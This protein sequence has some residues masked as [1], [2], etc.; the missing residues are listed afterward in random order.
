MARSIT[1]ERNQIIRAWLGELLLEMGRPREALLYYE[2]LG[3]GWPISQDP[4]IYFHLGRIRDQ[5]GDREG[6]LQS[7]ELATLAWRDADPRLQPM[8]QQA[9]QAA[10]R[11]RGLGRN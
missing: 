7:Y 9:R 6:A 8:V 5:L 1:S 4:I 10:A 11:L 3:P 2:S